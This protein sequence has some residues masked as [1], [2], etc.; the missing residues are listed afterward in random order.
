MKK[1]LEGQ[2]NEQIAVMFMVTERGLLTKGP[3]HIFTK[4]TFFADSGATCHMHSSLEGMF[5]LKPYVTARMVGKNEIMASVFKGQYK[6]IMLKNDLTSVVITL[7]DVLFI[8]ELMVNL[9]S[10]TKTIESTGVS[11]SSTGPIKLLEPLIFILFKVFKQSSG[12]LLGIEIIP[13]QN[14]IAATTQINVVHE[15]FCHPN[16]Q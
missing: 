7:Q 8:P 15:M 6:G 5:D 2:S 9:C 1:H 4:N 13:T 3:S 10:L 11:L 12:R 16:S 14:H